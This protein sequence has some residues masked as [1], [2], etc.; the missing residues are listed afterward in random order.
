MPLKRNNTLMQD[1]S[2]T[3]LIFSLAN[4]KKKIDWKR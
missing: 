1:R 3:V 2:G 4:N